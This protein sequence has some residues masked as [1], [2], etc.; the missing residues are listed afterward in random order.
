MLSQQM[1]GSEQD[2]SRFNTFDLVRLFAACQG[3][4]S[5]GIRHLDIAIEHPVVMFVN[6]IR[7][8]FPGVPI[9]FCQWV[10]DSKVLG[11]KPWE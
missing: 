6:D 3:V 9:F 1:A 11:M 8:G 7:V 5:H 10:S 4:Y 2:P